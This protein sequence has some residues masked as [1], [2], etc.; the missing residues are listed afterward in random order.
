MGRGSP[1]SVSLS[2]LVPIRN[3]ARSIKERGYGWEGGTKNEARLMVNRDPSLILSTGRNHSLCCPGLQWPLSESQT[4]TMSLQDTDKN[5]GTLRALLGKWT[6]DPGPGCQS[7]QLLKGIYS[8]GKLL[9]VSDALDGSPVQEF[10][11]PRNCVLHHG[12]SPSWDL[13][14]SFQGWD[15]GL[16]SRLQKSLS[17][18]KATDSYCDNS[19]LCQI[20]SSVE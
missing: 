5:M 6:G 8:C 15:S 2:Q 3:A 20:C 11:Y 9:W 19:M 17:L 18:E 1:C 14:L 12:S 7:M 13:S 4:E 16:S 10:R